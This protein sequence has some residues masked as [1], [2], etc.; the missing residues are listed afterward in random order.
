MNARHMAHNILDRVR[1]GGYASAPLM[2]RALVVT[3]D[4]PEMSAAESA[5]CL[6]NDA[7]LYAGA[8]DMGEWGA[9]NSA[10]SRAPARIPGEAA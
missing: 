5:H 9:L 7:D 10:T 4:I 3:G 1:A 6:R 2:R 8:D